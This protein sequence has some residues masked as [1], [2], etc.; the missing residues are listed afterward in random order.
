MSILNEEEFKILRQ[1]KG[2]IDSTLL[3][4]ILN[5]IE[6]DFEKSHN[7]SS[8]IIFIYTNY[9]TLIKQNKE[10]FDLLSKIL[11]KYSPKIGTENVIQLIINSLK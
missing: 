5:E 1:Y 9:L 3:E 6:E 10:F 11:Q 8:S 4:R 2:K 7:L